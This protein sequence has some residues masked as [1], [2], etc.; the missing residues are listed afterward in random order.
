ML[1]THRKAFI[2]DTLNRE[3]PV[4]AQRVAEMLDLSE[5]T[6]RRDLRELAADGLLKRVHGGA[7]PVAPDLPDLAA[8]NAIATDEKT[9]LA[10]AA[11]AL[12]QPGQMV[13][14]DGGSTHALV[15]RLLPRSFAFT[16]ATHSP[17]IAA[18]LEDHPTAEVILCGGKIYK[19]SMV[20]VGAAAI[21]SIGLISPELF[22]LGVTAAHPQHGL[23]T[24]DVEEAAIKRFI[25]GR[26]AETYVTLTA[27]KLDKVSPAGV[28][29]LDAVAGLI[30]AADMPEARMAPYREAG[31]AVIRA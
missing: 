28:L 15:A 11:A 21:A 30:V 25:A 13:F 29:G 2:L 12:V 6:I 22:L 26:S 5:D 3:G 19:H 24:G 9:A 1:T 18:A 31:A 10:A 14:L 23:S 7:L 27:D 4:I 16:V 8:R 17:T 20:A